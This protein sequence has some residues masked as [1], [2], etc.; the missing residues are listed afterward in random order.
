MGADSYNA[1][2][3][4]MFIED[5]IVANKIKKNIEYGIEPAH[6]QHTSKPIHFKQEDLDQ[7]HLLL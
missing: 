3:D 6:Q 1:E 7:I 5:K 4:N 2:V